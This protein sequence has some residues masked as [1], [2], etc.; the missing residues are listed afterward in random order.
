MA[1]STL[2][3]AL[4]SILDEKLIDNRSPI[5]AL[6]KTDRQKKAIL[7]KND[8]DKDTFIDLKQRRIWVT[9][10]HKTP[11]AASG[12]HNR[13]TGSTVLNIGPKFNLNDPLV[14]NE[15]AKEKRLRSQA[16]RG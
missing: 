6:T 7:S 14:S 8:S 15:L 9:Q 2:S 11:L 1:F 10:A 4:K 13:P 3:Q 5:L 12:I 16:T